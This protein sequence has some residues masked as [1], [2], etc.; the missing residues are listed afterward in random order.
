[1]RP[2]RRLSPVKSPNSIPSCKM[3]NPTTELDNCVRWENQLFIANI[4]DRLY[5]VFAKHQSLRWAAFGQLKIFE[6]KILT[7][8]FTEKCIDWPISGKSE[9]SGSPYTPPGFL[10][11]PYPGYP[12]PPHLVSFQHR[13]N[14][15][16]VLS[17]VCASGLTHGNQKSPDVS[18][19]SECW[20]HTTFPNVIVITNQNNSLKLCDLCTK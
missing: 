8:F 15:Y 6:N 5:M 14:Y 4:R 7:F 12:P 17:Q 2:H 9:P 3:G 18:Y 11:I 20:H 16:Q 19:K 10:S 1:M 13:V